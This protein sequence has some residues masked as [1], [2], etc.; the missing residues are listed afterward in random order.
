MIHTSA[1]ASHG[2]P[3]SRRAALRR[4]IP[5]ARAAGHPTDRD[6]PERQRETVLGGPASLAR[7]HTAARTSSAGG[8]D[9]GEPIRSASDARRA[10]A[11]RSNWTLFR[12]SR[13]LRNVRNEI[14][15]EE[16]AGREHPRDRFERR[17]EIAFASQRL[18][19]AVRRQHRAE[20]VP[21]ERAAR[22]CRREPVWRCSADT[23]AERSRSAGGARRASVPIGRCR[24]ST[25]PRARAAPRSVPC[26]TP[27]RAP[28][29]SRP[30]RCGARTAH[31][32]PDG[33][34][35]LPVVKRRVLV[36]ALP[37]FAFMH[38]GIL[39]RHCRFSRS[40]DSHRDHIVLARALRWTSSN[41]GATSFRSCRARST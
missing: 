10:A 1:R 31:L 18:Q 7:A 25:R 5:R 41:A 23:R 38:R 20:V 15:A 22:G 28:A 8:L 32:P 29:A 17:R 14:D 30:R 33:S 19:D 12:Y 26:R 4:R 34:R 16:A 2:R 11:G 40:R 39:I 35:V 9:P 37:A 6:R 27:A 13:Q 36:P 24:P 3:C 21:S